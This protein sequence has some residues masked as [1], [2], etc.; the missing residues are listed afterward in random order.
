[1]IRRKEVLNIKPDFDFDLIAPRE[2]IVFFDIETTG[3][4]SKHSALYLI[5]LVTYENDSWCLTQLFAES[6]SEEAQLLSIFFDILNA[7]KRLGRV[8]LI[9]YNG[10]GFDIPFINS[11]IN[12]CKLP[13]SLDGIISIDLI[14]K[15]RPYKRL[16]GLCDCRL[17]TV[18]RLCG[19]FREDRYNGGELIYVYE[20]FLRLNGLAKDSC[21]NTEQNRKLRDKL[22]YTLLL[23]NAEDIADMPMIMGILGYDELFNGGFEVTGSTVID[24]AA[25]LNVNAEKNSVGSYVWDIHARLNIPLPKGIYRENNGTVISIGEEDKLKL[26]LA[27]TLISGELKYFFSDYKEYYYLPNEDCAVHKSVG[28]YVERTARKRA[29]ARNCYQRVKGIFT[30]QYDEIFTPAFYSEYK[31]KPCYGNLAEIIEKT[32]GHID[33]DISKRY[34]MSVI[35]RLLM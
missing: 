7:K 5:G 14:K 22:L 29:T 24:T 3:L 1:M 35:N 9:S 4:S 32:D 16:L 30:P 19:I 28:E 21:E 6:I 20:E 13:F 18:E 10:D 33:T 12:S 2:R 15:I 27:V 11:C 34:I 17:K 23:H 8:M 31:A 25:F 26:N